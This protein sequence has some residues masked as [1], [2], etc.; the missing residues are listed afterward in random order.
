VDTITV[1][2]DGLREHPRNYRTHPDDQLEHLARSIELHGFYRPVVL[3]RDHTILAGHGVVRAAARLGRAEVPA[4]RLDLDPDEP[5]A[6][7]LL[8][9]DNE[10]GNLADVDDRALTEL[11]R[12]LAQDDPGLLLG[13]GFDTQQLSALAYVTRS[14]DEMADF[15]AA[16]EWLG[17]PGFQK[18]DDVPTLLV[19]FDS[20]DERLKFLAEIGYGIERVSRIGGGHTIW[21]PDR[22]Q[23]DLQSLRFQ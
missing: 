2:I 11:L 14:R 18:A 21:W 1:P 8:A 4:V 5:R 12:E 23:N 13:T 16:E 10:T 7:Q 9:G 15:D 22:P 19:K 6:L 3:A 17:L 20:D